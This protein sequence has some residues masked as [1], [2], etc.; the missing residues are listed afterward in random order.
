[1]RF[2]GL[3]LAAV[4]AR[5]LH[6]RDVILAEDQEAF[7]ARF[8]RIVPKRPTDV[9]ELRAQAPDGRAIRERG[10]D[11]G[12]FRAEGRPSTIPSVGREIA[13]RRQAEAE[14][15]GAPA[16]RGAG[17]ENPCGRRTLRADPAAC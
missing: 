16:M 1:M 3:S 2:V 9:I 11:A 10:T 12:P 5:G 15:R 6:D 4:R 8:G 17:R 7:G 13:D 14:V